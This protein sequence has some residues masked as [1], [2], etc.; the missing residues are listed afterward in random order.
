MF[1]LIVDKFSVVTT[2]KI[3]VTSNAKTQP[4][5]EQTGGHQTLLFIQPCTNSQAEYSFMVT[6]KTSTGKLHRIT[7]N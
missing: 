3:L 7:S 6:N 4:F 5:T 2:D 1:A